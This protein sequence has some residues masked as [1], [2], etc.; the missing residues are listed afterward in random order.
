VYDQQAVQAVPQGAD[1]ARVMHEY[2]NVIE[3]GSIHRFL[4]DPMRHLVGEVL[5]SK[6]IP[7]LFR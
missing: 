5:F 1:A 4:I 3:S 6:P 2:R 7:Y